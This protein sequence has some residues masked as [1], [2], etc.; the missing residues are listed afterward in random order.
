MIVQDLDWEEFVA[1]FPC[2]GY[3]V[4]VMILEEP[5][6]GMFVSISLAVVTN[7]V[8]SGLLDAIYF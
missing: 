7:E 6:V 2:V 3:M 1:G 5:M 4:M 8:L